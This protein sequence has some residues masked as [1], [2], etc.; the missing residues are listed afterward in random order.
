MQ[1]SEDAG[2]KLHTFLVKQ[3]CPSS[4]F[5]IGGTAKQKP[6]DRME[7]AADEN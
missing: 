4:V 3:L 2:K 7:L 1:A 5:D 6:K